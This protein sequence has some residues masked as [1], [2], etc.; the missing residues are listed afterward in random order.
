[1]ALQFHG[2]QNITTTAY[3]AL[4]NVNDTT[5]RRCFICCTINF[6][7]STDNA[8]TNQ[9]ILSLPGHMLVDLG[10]VSPASVS[11]QATFSDSQS[12]AS[13]FSLDPGEAR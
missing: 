8:V 11:A 3:T 7:V 9:L 6:R 10:V 13:L 1:M 5:P 12:Q 2:R 4:A